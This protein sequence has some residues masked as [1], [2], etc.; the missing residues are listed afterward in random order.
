MLSENRGGTC[1]TIFNEEEHAPLY[2][3]ICLT[4]KS[5]KARFFSEKEKKT[6]ADSPLEHNTK[7][8]NKI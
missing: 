3:T 4:Q 1:P 2:F 5:D 7:I 8:I 6:T